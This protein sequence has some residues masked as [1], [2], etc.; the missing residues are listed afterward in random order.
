MPP[1]RLRS[2][3]RVNPRFHQSDIS[4]EPDEVERSDP[5]ETSSKATWA[6]IRA[7]RLPRP[8]QVPVRTSRPCHVLWALHKRHFPLR[9]NPDNRRSRELS[10]T[11]PLTSEPSPDK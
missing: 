5:T 3:L 10:T 6:K 4:P 8:D 7:T 2:F 9:C 1:R 11:R